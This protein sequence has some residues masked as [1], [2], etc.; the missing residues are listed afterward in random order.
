MVLCTPTSEP[1]R[2]LETCELA[3]LAGVTPNAVRAAAARGEL[4][5]FAET[6]RGKLYSFEAAQEWLRQR[7]E[8]KRAPE[9]LSA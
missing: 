1:L 6:R 2:L 9:A 5:P 7:A 4:A 3:S 8:R